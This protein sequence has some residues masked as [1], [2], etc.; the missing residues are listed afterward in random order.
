MAK[1]GWQVLDE[2]ESRVMKRTASKYKRELNLIVDL[3]D[4]PGD[5]SSLIDTTILHYADP[6]FSTDS[7]GLAPIQPPL[8]F[9]AT[10]VV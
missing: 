4:V 7:G 5:A 1:E 8:A 9:P 6:S 3:L 10:Q 2:E